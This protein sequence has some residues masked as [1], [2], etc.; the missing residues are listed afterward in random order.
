MDKINWDLLSQNPSIF[1]LD[2]EALEQR[3]NIYKE[4]LIKK[5]LHP[6]VITQYIN[7]PNLKDTNIEYILDNCI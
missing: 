1:E 7:H 3:C 6:R 2:F 4:E 5:A